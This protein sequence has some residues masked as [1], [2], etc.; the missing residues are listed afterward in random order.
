MSEFIFYFSIMIYLVFGLCI[1]WMFLRD[2]D[3]IKNKPSSQF[4]YMS[5]IKK[6]SDFYNKLGS[7][8]KIIISITVI[9]F[10]T[11]LTIYFMAYWGYRAFGG[12]QES[13]KQIFS[14]IWNRCDSPRYLQIAQ[15]G[16]LAEGDYNSIINIAFYPF[17][18]LLIRILNYLINDYFYSAI[19]VSFISLVVACFFFYKLLLID[20]D[21]DT[22]K[23][24]VKYFLIFPFSLFLSA[25]YT[26]SVFMAL[27]F[28]FFYG[29]RKKEWF[30]AGTAG[31][32]AA[33]T[34]TQGFLLLIPMI[35]E[36]ILDMREKNKAV[37]GKKGNKFIFES[38]YISSILVP[39][40]YGG[41]LLIN[42]IVTG[43]WF[44]YMKYQKEYWRNEVEIFQRFL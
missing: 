44:K 8:T 1:L 38:S 6:I 18:P 29:V 14:A 23:R 20:Y 17:Y 28:M 9:L 24:A 35:Y 15:E 4:S 33:F 39:L 40:G 43:D 5:L 3:I 16:Y 26:E 41:Y 37:K 32:F 13:F 42:K 25:V 11:R 7:N 27:C 12:E 22:S 34:R 2:F 30:F 10:F 36:I 19:I 21:E 31:M